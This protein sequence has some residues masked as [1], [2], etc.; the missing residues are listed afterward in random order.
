MH[1][2]VVAD[3]D[4]VEQVVSRL[5]GSVLVQLGGDI[6]VVGVLRRGGPLGG[7]LATRLAEQSGLEVPF[8]ELKLKRYDD[9][10]TVL[11]DTPRLE[12]SSLPFEVAGKT[13]LLVDDVLY[14]GRTLFQAALHLDRLGAARVHTAVLCS[15]LGEEM[16]V[17][18]DFV[19]MRLEVSPACII[20][21]H[22]PPYE[23]RL[24]VTL[25]HRP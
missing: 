16:P 12:E 2:F 11:H 15:R 8:G 25:E 22:I 17:R 6:V 21:V 1:G 19:G 10:L 13:V 3:A 14:T 7:M 20:H 18:G 9:S 24:G 4:W 5:A 23:E